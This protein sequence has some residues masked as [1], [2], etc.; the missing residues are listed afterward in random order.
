MS[1][2]L[3]ICLEFGTRGGEDWVLLTGKLDVLDVAPRSSS[4]TGV[5][6]SLR[7]ASHK[8]QHVDRLVGRW[9]TARVQWDQKSLSD[10]DRD[11]RR[12]KDFDVKGML[13][14]QDSWGNYFI[15]PVTRFVLDDE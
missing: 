4:R 9:V 14:R 6:F 15:E 10:R 8:H 5:H 1:G 12:F 13:H 11:E 7:G 2:V 3:S